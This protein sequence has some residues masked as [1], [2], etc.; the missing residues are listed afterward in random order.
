MAKL[1]VLI[2]KTNDKLE[3]FFAGDIKKRV[4]Q[5]TV[6]RINSILV[7][8]FTGQLRQAAPNKTG[9]LAASLNTEATRGS[10]GFSV[11]LRITS[12]GPGSKYI[13]AVLEGRGAITIKGN[14]L[15]SFIG[16]NHRAGQRVVV[17]SVKS[18]AIPPNDFITPV[19]ERSIRP[20]IQDVITQSM[21]SI[22]TIR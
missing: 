8:R 2:V 12:S 6:N 3:S 21:S 4:S 15:L 10:G 9:A 19:Y 1:E 11:G 22:F 16:T 18:P 13:K 17:S 20:S 5:E 7:P 14:P